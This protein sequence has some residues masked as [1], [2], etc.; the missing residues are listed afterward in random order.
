MTNLDRLWPG[1]E[2][3][4]ALSLH[5]ARIQ[6]AF[7]HV[8]ILWGESAVFLA[9]ALVRAAWPAADSV[10][11]ELP[12]DDAHSPH[13]VTVYDARGTVLADGRQLS[14]LLAELHA[15]TGEEEARA[16]VGALID[17]HL[18]LHRYEIE[19]AAERGWSHTAHRDDA[20]DPASP[21]C[22]TFQLPAP[23]ALPGVLVDRDHD[24]EQ[25]EESEAEGAKHYSPAD[26]ESDSFGTAAG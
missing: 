25:E 4:L 18:R 26:L 6:E 1:D 19:D 12:A 5:A 13:S 3:L 21:W 20:E 23:R 15:D 17:A 9:A 2:H 10:H 7:H 8:R 24:G 16:G 14:V 11:L 22:V